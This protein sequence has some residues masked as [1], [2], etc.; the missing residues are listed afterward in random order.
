MKQAYLLV[1]WAFAVLT[2]S[3][4]AGYLEDINK[5]CKVIDFDSIPEP[6][7]ETFQ[8]TVQNLVN[9][10][11]LKSA[12]EDFSTLSDRTTL[13]LKFPPKGPDDP[14]SMK[15]ISLHYIIEKIGKDGT[16]INQQSIDQKLSKA[17][18]LNLK[19]GFGQTDFSKYFLA[20]EYCFQLP[21]VV[22]N[23]EKS[24]ENIK[25]I[26]EHK[27]F[28]VSDI[29]SLTAAV[30]LKR[31][32]VN[33][34]NKIIITV[35]NRLKII[36]HLIQGTL[37]L[38]TIGMKVCRFRMFNFTF[39][40]TIDKD[41]AVFTALHPSKQKYVKYKLN[42]FIT[43]DLI[44]SDQE[45]IEN[46]KL[47]KYS[48]EAF[49][50][51]NIRD[52]LY[53]QG[54]IIDEFAGE[55]SLATFM[56]GFEYLYRVAPV[57]ITEVLLC[58]TKQ[59]FIKPDQKD[60]KRFSMY[61][62]YWDYCKDFFKGY[63]DVL[64]K[65]EDYLSWNVN[66]LQ[67]YQFMKSFR[68]LRPS[69]IADKENFF[70]SYISQIDEYDKKDRYIGYKFITNMLFRIYLRQIKK[71]SFES[72]DKWHDHFEGELIDSYE[73]IYPRSPLT[74]PKN[75]GYIF[76]EKNINQLIDY[77]ISIKFSSQQLGI[78]YDTVALA[79]KNY[80]D[81]STNVTSYLETIDR[82]IEKQ[83]QALRFLRREFSQIKPRYLVDIVFQVR[84]GK[85]FIRG[86]EALKVILITNK[87][88]K[89][90]GMLVA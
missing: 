7:R 36:R 19:Y 64:E 44:P 75:P 49:N 45:C 79:Y 23:N 85:I 71:L 30:I 62:I 6:F 73:L 12:T 47:Y 70:D 82:A 13:P 67:L 8:S 18:R 80:A 65:T 28:F 83:E 55:F 17:V 63:P 89:T 53:K 25:E 81:P 59:Y 2:L 20:T 29:A 60:A 88:I 31:G 14:A 86:F 52:D 22:Q 78:Y 68:Q 42:Q 39:I 50:P 5:F 84:N 43:N 34:E 38:K 54:K 26:R 90:Q 51:D 21:V 87:K 66:R 11:K 74:I 76:D 3:V 27:I 35:L 16:V 10:N 33:P 72:I 32:Y 37:Y 41:A 77:I 61:D 40:P 69:V 1:L 57:D 9:Q 46:S 56:L 58:Y 48:P 4:H 15:T 24:V